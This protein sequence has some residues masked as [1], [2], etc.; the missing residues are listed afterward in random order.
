M[1]DWIPV[2]SQLKYGMQLTNSDYKGASL[3]KRYF[4]G[5]VV[6]SKV[7]KGVKSTQKDCLHVMSGFVN[8]IPVFGHVKG[9]IR[10]LYDNRKDGYTAINH[11]NYTISLT[12]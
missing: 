4:Y 7:V 12:Y 5:Q 9:L 3:T 6:N 2:S 1:M 8:D 11:A 10:N